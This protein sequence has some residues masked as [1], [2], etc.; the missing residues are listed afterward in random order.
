MLVDCDHVIHL[1]QCII[2]CI[3]CFTNKR[4][5]FFRVDAGIATKFDNGAHIPVIPVPPEWIYL[6]VFVCS[7]Q[8]YI[9]E[10]TSV[11]LYLHAFFTEL[12]GKRIKS[13]QG[14]R[15]INHFCAVGNFSP[16]IFTFTQPPQHRISVDTTAVFF[17]A[18]KVDHFIKKRIISYT[19][20]HVERH[21]SNSHDSGIRL[22]AP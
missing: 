18:A 10:I 20:N 22:V 14:N 15:Q 17:A 5:I 6:T 1:V 16:G 21:S 7:T 2:Q 11:T 19:G 12:K 4:E 8:D 3:V 9:I 13:G